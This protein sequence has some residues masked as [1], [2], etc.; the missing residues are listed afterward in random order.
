M[1]ERKLNEK[2]SL[3]LI[4]QMIQNTKNRLETNCG[5]P[6]LFW[7]YTTLFVSL[8]IWFLV[9]T[10]GNY[11]W[12]YLWFLLPIIAGTG[13]Y[14][15]TRNQ[16]PGIKTHLDK[17][18]NYIWLVFGITGFLISMLAMFFWQLPILFIILLLMG[19]GTTLTGLVVGYKTVTICGTLG[20]LSSI[21]CLF[22]P[23]PNQILIFA[24]VFIFMM[25]IPGH[26]LNRNFA[27]M[28][29]ELNPLLHSELRLAVMS[30]L[31]SVEEAEF[32]YLKQQTGAT[33]GNLSV[34][35]DKLNKAGYVEVIKT[36]KGKMPC[37]IC[38]ITPKGLEAFEEYVD[39][40]K[41]YININT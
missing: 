28:F 31:V 3:E 2:E 15:S 32:S 30:I 21:G 29:K 18:I 5:M 41:S 33:A 40:L 24:P 11:Y 10:T 13:T 38:K 9:V 4:A 16:Q 37:T 34:Q 17:V 35:I 36:F 14:L 8:L 22:Y 23:G 26:V 27:P 19:M 6:F 20:A 1:E 7:G 12:Q 39:A 25:V